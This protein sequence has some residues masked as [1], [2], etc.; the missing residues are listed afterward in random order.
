M[1]TVTHYIIPHVTQPPNAAT[2]PDLAVFKS[3]EDPISHIYI[4][5]YIL[6]FIRN[7]I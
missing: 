6:T 7:I 2:F 5:T 4:P 1:I 3:V